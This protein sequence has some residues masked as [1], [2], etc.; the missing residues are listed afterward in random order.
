[1]LWRFS[2]SKG[3]W[4]LLII[5]GL[6]VSVVPVPV[7]RAQGVALELSVSGSDRYGMYEISGKVVASDLYPDGQRIYGNIL[8]VNVVWVS[9]DGEKQRGCLQ[10]CPL[11]TK[12]LPPE[13]G[14]TQHIPLDH[15]FYL[16]MDTQRAYIEACVTQ[17]YDEDGLPKDRT[18]C[19]SSGDLPFSPISLPTDPPPVETPGDQGVEIRIRVESAGHES[20]QTSLYTKDYE[21]SSIKIY[22]YVTDPEGNPI[23]GATVTL[24]DL[25]ESATTDQNGWYELDVETIGTKP[26]QESLDWTLA[27]VM[28]TTPIPP[29]TE[30]PPTTIPTLIPA[31]LSIED[32]VVLLQA[33]EGGKLV[34]GREIALTVFPYWKEHYPMEIGDYQI[35]VTVNVD[36]KWSDQKMSGIGQQYD[37]VIPGHLSTP[38]VTANHQI[39]VEASVVGADVADPDLTN[40]RYD[41]PFTTYRS[42][43]MRLLFVRILNVGV[44]PLSPRELSTFAGKSL[45]FLRQ[46]YPV[47]QVV[48]VNGSYAVWPATETLPFFI[49]KLPLIDELVHY[50]Y[51]S[52]AVARTLRQH[53]NNRCL[54][55][56]GGRIRPIIPCNVPKADLAV[57]VFR[58]QHYGDKQGWL[59]G[60]G[61]QTF[62]K[63]TGDPAKRLAGWLVAGGE[64]I[65]RAT[66]TTSDNHWNTAHEI[67]HHFD[68]EDEYNGRNYGIEL[69][70]VHIWQDGKII[71]IGPKYREENNIIRYIS[72][73]G[74]AGV[75]YNLGN[76]TWVNAA[77]WNRILD[78]INQSGII[79]A[80]PDVVASL[81][82]MANIPRD[83]PVDVLGPALLVMGT[84]DSQGQGM[85][86]T[87]DHLHRYEAWPAVEGEWRLEALDEAGNLLGALPFDT[88]PL[89]LEYVPFLA[90]L[91]VGDA[92]QVAQIRLSKA[93]TVHDTIIRSPS[94]PTASFHVLPDFSG[95]TLEIVWS[96]DDVDGDALRSSV[97]YSVDGGLTWHVLALD[98]TETHFEI[99]P[100]ELP[101]GEAQFRVVV[102]DGLNESSILTPPVAVP[103]RPPSV[104][105]QLPWGDTF[106]ADEPVLLD[107]YGYDLEDGEIPPERLQWLDA[108]GQ[109]LGQGT[110]L[111]LEGLSSGEHRLVLQAQDAAGQAAQAGVTIT[112]Q[113]ELPFGEDGEDLVLC[114]SGIL[115]ALAATLGLVGVIVGLARRRLEPALAS[116]AAQGETIRQRL[117]AGQLQPSQVVPL[118]GQDRRGR[119]WSLEPIN[120]AWYRWTGKAWQPVRP[121]RG[122]RRWGCF[123]GGLL[124]LVVGG[125]LALVVGGAALLM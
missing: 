108:A 58:G 62:G 29:D 59:Y 11:L 97:F 21:P 123:V 120:G 122:G 39:L 28:P 72:F 36:G 47:P 15:A 73:M 18:T 46:V 115:A 3:F 12:F 14:G 88:H 86:H 43:P 30:T 8:Y 65:H 35:Q 68:L 61:S 6:L 74:E 113:G 109:S 95:D 27:Q 101:G 81:R 20:F 24:I 112:V 48:R 1:M 79:Q 89:D 124:A 60:R 50:G 67:G 116:L 38:G 13:E 55:Y 4:I 22:G 63:W 52:V 49:D 57:A 104:D 121:P 64:D 100:Q 90:T 26:Y 37:F 117:Q 111:R 98:L 19:T 118:Q 85:I 40:N 84:V 33:V 82:P 5:V 93:G 70:H 103:N 34:S 83:E 69:E 10:G 71:Q 119:Q 106:A 94:S 77:S 92:G 105:I 16:H 102:S 23:P 125:L 45:A 9:S 80:T 17:S 53:N 96:S 2:R 31:D 32:A 110:Q 41:K 56:S 87:I 44:T 66:T 42:L 114:G 107:G 54:D 76:R 75:E 25:Y 99:D 7:V 51:V 91:P 78:E